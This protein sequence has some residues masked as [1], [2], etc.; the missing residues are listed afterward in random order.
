MW[1]YKKLGKSGF[2][3]AG[4]TLLSGQA[5]HARWA[6][7]TEGVP[8]VRL[9]E[10][11]SRYVQEHPEDAEGHYTLGRIHSL[12]FA[13]DAEKLD[14]IP[15]G[16]KYKQG[17]AEL[18]GFASYQ[19]IQVT[20]PKAD[21]P[22][23]DSARRHLL[24]S[25]ASYEK[26]TKLAPQ[27]ALY[28]LGLGWMREQ[29]APFLV[30]SDKQPEAGEPTHSERA[31]KWRAQA[32][33]AYRESYELAL[34]VDSKKQ[35]LGPA[36]DS[37]ISVEAGEGILR[38]LSAKAE[39]S[40]TERQ[41]INRVRI[42]IAKIKNLPRAVTPIILPL[43]QDTSLKSL[44]APGKS[45]TFDLAGDGL[46]KRWPWVSAETGIL[47]WDKQGTGQITSGRQLF[48]S[49]TWWIFWKNGYDALAA[50]DNDG[51]GCLI[52]QELDGLAIWRDANGNGVSDASE[53]KPLR[54]WGISALAAR[55]TATIEGV[56]ANLRGYQRSDGT[57][58][59]TYDWTPQSLP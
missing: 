49:V 48:G 6:R 31:A 15:A 3:L 16:S 20:P 10:N 34:E 35:G 8:T 50:L 58:L 45:T 54:D 5:G 41:E 33:D 42:A 55:S 40:D 24:A 14:V 32:L 12:A 18:P 56:P 38:I 29:G 57:W 25:V 27:N 13:M 4:L 22:L 37:A 2:L 51:D 7:M 26:A 28:K 43:G 19:S 52:G 39:P 44:L 30:K 36:A 59:P 17:K 47:V 1:N 9:I 46:G 21:N 23:S 53:V 11:V